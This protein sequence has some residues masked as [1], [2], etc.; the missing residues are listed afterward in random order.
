MTKQLIPANRRFLPYFAQGH[1]FEEP[2]SV[3]AAFSRA[4]MRWAVEPTD[5]YTLNP[6]CGEFDEIEGQRAIRRTDTMRALGVVGSKYETIDNVE[7]EAMLDGAGYK[8][9]ALG[10]FDGGRKCFAILDVGPYSSFNVNGDPWNAYLACRWNHDG[11]GGLRYGVQLWRTTCIN[12]AQVIAG[13]KWTTIRH[14]S[15][16]PLRMQTAAELIPQLGDAMET[17][18]AKTINLQRRRFTSK[19]EVGRFLEMVWPKPKE[20]GSVQGHKAAVT[21]WENTQATA[22]Q[23]LR[24]ET[25]DGWDLTAYGAVNAVNELEQWYASSRRD[26]SRSQLVRLDAERF[27]AT[28]RALALVG[29]V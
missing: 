20:K 9:E 29:A 16:A 13:F 12:G 28:E 2:L 11:G 27:P 26:I 15:G 22:R 24:S 8:V 21:R 17:F 23:I 4:N 3:E 25:S 19:S 6:R 5:V 1:K 7:V 18:V 14:T 10:E